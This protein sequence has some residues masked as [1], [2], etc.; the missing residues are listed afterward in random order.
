MVKYLVIVESPAKAKTI[1]KFL[2]KSYKVQACMGH[3]RDLPK[4]KLGIDIENNFKPK[5]INITSKSSLIKTLAKEAQGSNTIYLATDL[6]R[7]GEA[8]AWHL[9][10]ALKIPEKKI[11]RVIFNEITKTAIKQAFKSPMSIQ[12][13]KVYAQQARRILDRIVGYKLSPLLWKK[14]TKG[15]SAGRVQTV[16][17]KL[18][19]DKEKEIQKFKSEEYWEIK[20]LVSTKNKIDHIFDADLKKYKNKK[21]KITNEANAKEHVERLTK[22]SLVI[23]KITYKEKKEK[24]SPPFAT[25][26]LQQQASIKLGFSAK[27]TMLI[28]QQL[29]EGLELGAKE[30]VG[31]ITYMRTDSF[32]I[33]KDSIEECRKFIEQNF[34]DAYLPKKAQFFKNKK[35]SQGAHEAIRPTSVDRTPENIKSY[36]SNDQYKLYKL[37]WEKFVAS[38]MSP[39]RI[40]STNITIKAGEDYI[41][42][43]KGRQLL[44]DGYQKLVPSKGK[45]SDKLLP[46][47]IEKEILNL[48]EIKPSQHFTQPPA[49]YSEATLVK[50]L[51]RKGI[52][53]PSTYA[54]IISTIQDRGYVELKNKAFYATE[55]GIKITDQLTKF[56]TKIMDT[57]FTSN[58][59]NN[60]DEVEE[61][62]VEWVKI[63]EEFYSFFASD[64][65][66]A[67]KEME[68]IKKNPEY[69][70]HL[71]E[72][73]KTNMVIKYNKYG[74]FLGCPNFPDCKYTISLDK[75]GNAVFPQE[76]EYKCNKCKKAMIIRTGKLGKFFACS[77]YPECKNILPIGTDGEPVYPED[78][79]VKCEKCGSPMVKKQGKHGSFIACS[80][81]PEC[82]NTRPL[83]NNIFEKLN[84]LVKG[85]CEKCGKKF[86][87]KGGYRGYFLGC[88][89]YPDCKNIKKISSESI[90]I[91]SHVQIPKCENCNQPLV[92]KSARKGL[93]WGCSNYPKCKIILPCDLEKFLAGIN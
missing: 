89:G 36:L 28:A 12:M 17:V 54:P 23:E 79:G 40:S 33:S 15:L 85:K 49:R 50:M 64:L 60:L 31:L 93:F 24:P 34:S 86:T 45:N 18:I 3:I 69:S 21:I 83:N 8:I 25:S 51:E 80:K 38:Q 43:S 63:V 26:Q 20:T 66:I 30:R 84:K 46:D 81:Y 82:K 6:D 57:T 4:T 11:A 47:L 22:N 19:A 13:N 35:A 27:R 67:Y 62:K 59:E 92:I 68:S 55:L 77:G 72:K 5:Y 91:P 44:F 56:F 9:S 10:K 75:D 73:C 70:S 74:K 78:T 29:Y 61:G 71:C 39:A 41:L 32:H 53:R 58:L 2:G 65:E 87:V 42:E 14:F 16:A 1:N 7:E 76:T 52:G 37:I 48:H 88:S 90:N